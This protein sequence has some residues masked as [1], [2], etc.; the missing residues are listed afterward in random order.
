MD[1]LFLDLIQVALNKRE[2]LRRCPSEQEWHQLFVLCQI[3]SVVGIAFSAL[4][5]LSEKGQRPPLSIL[6]KWIGTA[7]NIKAQNIFDNIINIFL[8]LI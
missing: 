6:Y 3:Q 2:A 7:E 8:Y 1:A 4:D 5:I